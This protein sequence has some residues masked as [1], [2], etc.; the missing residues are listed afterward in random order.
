VRFYVVDA[1]GLRYGPVDLQGLQE[2]VDQGRV[3]ALMMIVDERTGQSSQ[4]RNIPGLLF[5]QG[6]P[7]INQNPT[8][9]PQGWN[10]PGAPNIG[11]YGQLAGY[12]RYGETRTY[13]ATMLLVK[14]ILSA[15]FCCTIPGVVAIV[16]A[17]MTM[18]HG[19]SGRLDQANSYAAQANNWANWAIGLGVVQVVLGLCIV[20]GQMAAR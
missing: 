18:S 1:G 20:V 15:L 8:Q 2:W 12:T 10:Q 7:S 19:S 3:T 6:A 14:S 13:D 11:G 4:A 5:P 17:A 9:S 16:F